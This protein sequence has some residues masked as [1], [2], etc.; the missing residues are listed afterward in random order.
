MRKIGFRFMTKCPM[1]Y[2]VVYIREDGG[3]SPCSCALPNLIYGN[4]F[5]ETIEEIWNNQKFIN[6]RKY[7]DKICKKCTLFKLFD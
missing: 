6:F 2:D 5:K 4:I 3:V 1:S 7:Q